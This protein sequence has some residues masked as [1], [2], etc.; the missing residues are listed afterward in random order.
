MAKPTESILKNLYPHVAKQIQANMTGY[1]KVLSKFMNDRHEDLYDIGPCTRIFFGQSDIDDYFEKTKIDINK[2]KSAIQQT[3][4]GTIANFSPICAKDP[5]TICVL[6]TIRYFLL[7]KNTKETELAALYLAF[8]GKFYP[9]VHYGSFPKFVPNEHREVMEYVINNMLSNKYDLKTQGSTIGAVRSIVNT[10]LKTYD[11]RFKDFDDTD[12]VYVLDQ[13]R[14]RLASFIKNIA[15]LYYDAYDNKD[16]YL[17]YDSDNLSDDNYHL[18]DSDSFKAE[19]AIESAVNYITTSAVNYKYCKMAADNNVRTDE[20]KSIIES[21]MNNKES[22]I[23]IRELIRILVYSYYAQSK[24]KDV[25]DI[26]FI[27]FSLAPKPN[28]KDKNYLRQKEIL[29]DMLNENSPAYK[30]RKSRTATRLSY[31]K[32][33]LTYFVLVIHNASK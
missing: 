27:T 33:V 9:S 21:L 19:R 3:Y 6:C 29:E 5:F 14:N 1:K 26:D 17:T 7:K 24:R 22:L 16:A 25:R 15:T 20:I 18:A 28:S 23:D 2:A 32:A 4:Y 13:L 30:R 8:S 12:V 10:W 31:H 11:D